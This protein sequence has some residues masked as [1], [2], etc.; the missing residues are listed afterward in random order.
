VWDLSGTATPFG[1]YLFDIAVKVKIAALDSGAP[2]P[3]PELRVDDFVDSR[4][5]KMDV[6]RAVR[7]CSARVCAFLR[8]MKGGSYDGRRGIEVGG[9]HSDAAFEALATVLEHLRTFFV[10]FAFL[11]RPVWTRRDPAFMAASASAEALIGWHMLANPNATSSTVV[12]A[13]A[14][15]TVESLASIYLYFHDK[16]ASLERFDGRYAIL[17]GRLNI[18]RIEH[19]FSGWRSKCGHNTMTGPAAEHCFKMRIATANAD[20]SGERHDYSSAGLT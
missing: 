5:D 6:F 4:H 20:A 3:C 16:L 2:D 17:P 9:G 14:R 7:L 15:V 13:P 12:R 18:S 10:E 8:A 1:G 11:R 19:E